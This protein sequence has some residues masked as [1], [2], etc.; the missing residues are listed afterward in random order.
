[1]NRMSPRQQIDFA[2]LLLYS[3]R[4]QVTTKMIS[5]FKEN[6]QELTTEELQDIKNILELNGYAIFHQEPNT[7]DYV[8]LIT[9]KGIEFVKGNSFVK[10]GTSILQLF[11]S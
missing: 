9:D 11:E 1:M 4:R 10:P 7:V 2:L 8:G 3:G 5:A 6:G